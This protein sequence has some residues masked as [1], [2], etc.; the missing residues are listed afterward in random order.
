MMQEKVADVAEFAGRDR[1]REVLVVD[2]N[3]ADLDLTI[4]ALR[5][6]VFP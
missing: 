3:P 6:R 1:L 4:A 5:V 2:D